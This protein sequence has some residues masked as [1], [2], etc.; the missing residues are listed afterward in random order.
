MGIRFKGRTLLNEQIFMNCESCKKIYSQEY[1]FCP[2][3]GKK[4]KAVTTKVYANYGKSGVTS[5]SY[6]LPNGITFNSKNGL[7]MSLGNGISYTT[8]K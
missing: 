8:S 7:T 3:C 6:V 2:E 1:C 5:I 4:L